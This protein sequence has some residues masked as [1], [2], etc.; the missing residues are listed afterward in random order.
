MQL[1][2][3]LFFIGWM[4]AGYV[5]PDLETVRQDYRKASVSEEATKTLYDDLTAIGQNDAP[6]LVAYK[7]AVT[8]MMAEYAEG[9]KNKKSF[10]KEGRDLLEYAIET[11]PKNVEIRCIRLSVQENVPKITG[12][13]KN[14][15]EDKQFVL[16]NYS[17]IEDKGAKE[18]V[19]GF[20][21][22]SESFTDAE[23]QLF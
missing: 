12:Y 23:R 4:T 10:F 1:K 13:H 21:S 18:F 19:K 22:Q 16:D 3:L 15:D 6:V 14:K 2:L 20:A 7:G 8:T 9:I 5:F 17:S 11:E